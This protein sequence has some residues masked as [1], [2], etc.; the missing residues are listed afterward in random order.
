MQVKS[1]SRNLWKDPKRDHSL[2]AVFQGR[3]TANR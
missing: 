3:E 2:L 1:L